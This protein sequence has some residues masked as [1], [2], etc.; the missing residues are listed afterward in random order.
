[1]S[2]ILHI[3]LSPPDVYGCD[4][5]IC[6]LFRQSLVLELSGESTDGQLEAIFIFS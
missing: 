6:E 2:N 1:M 3:L 5:D 4:C